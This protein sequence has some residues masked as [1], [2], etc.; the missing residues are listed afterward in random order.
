MRISVAELNVD[1]P[2]RTD[3][4][5]MA[6]APGSPGEPCRTPDGGIDAPFEDGCGTLLNLYQG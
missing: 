2:P 5:L 3:R 6:R 1:D 4:P